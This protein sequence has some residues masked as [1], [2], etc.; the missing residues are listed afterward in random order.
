MNR[1]VMGM[2]V[3]G[4]VIVFSV[5]G[6]YLTGSFYFT[7]VSFVAGCAFGHFVVCWTMIDKEWW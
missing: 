1:N 4:V 6:A 5:T 3:S 7:P 2:I